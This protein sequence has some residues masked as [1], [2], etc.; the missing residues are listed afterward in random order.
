MRSSWV[1]NLAA[2]A[3]NKWNKINLAAFLVFLFFFL[4][5]IVSKYGKDRVII[6]ECVGIGAIFGSLIICGLF[7][8][9][10]W[11]F[12]AGVCVGVGCAILTIYYGLTS[13]MRTRKAS[14]PKR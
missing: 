14:P 6:C 2:G 8:L 1:L 9:S 3:W 13:W 4:Y 7:G 10:P 5:E 12:F 11:V